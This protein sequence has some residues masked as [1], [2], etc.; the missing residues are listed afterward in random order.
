MTIR[1]VTLLGL[2]EVGTILAAD[3]AVW[4]NLEIT[5]Y[6]CQF[7]NADSGPAA[8]LRAL[9]GVHGAAA[10]PA[11]A[12]TADLVISA[13]TA[14]E[15]VAAAR[16]CA[17]G[18]QAGT[19]FLDLNSVAPDTRCEAARIIE[20]AGGR[21]V[22]GAVMSP[23]PPRRCAA[24]ILLGGPHAAEFAPVAVAMGFAGARFYSA[25]TG[26]ASAAKMCRSVIVKGVE[27]LLTESL[28]A[29]R[30]YGVEAD[31]LSSLSD[32]FP[33]ADWSAR[34]GYMISR[35][36]EHGVRR[37]DEM[38]EVAKTV[39]EAGLEPLMSVAAARRQRWAAQ[40]RGS[41][42]EDLNTMLDGIRREL[43][44]KEGEGKC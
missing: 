13:V 26:R 22:E 11:A 5:A 34:A 18:L 15:D 10:A 17:H 41:M 37:A 42:H 29:A 1:R 44:G 30:H 9:D 39:R 43:P 2:G 12:A 4:G 38:D 16:D 33:D 8:A 35:S 20:A 40:F 28:L 6:D 19:W 3:L 31:V 25:E 27:A 7:S 24:P 32:L 36:L 23:V 21:Y 14:A